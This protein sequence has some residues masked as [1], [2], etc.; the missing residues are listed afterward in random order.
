MYR[1][2]RTPSIWR[3]MNRFQRDMNRLFNQYTPSRTRSA[4]SYPS[5]NI[6]T[7]ESGQV[8]IAEIPGV[9]AEDVDVNVNVD[10]LTISGKRASI[11]LPEG[12]HFVRRE[13]DF[14][15]FTRTIQLPFPVDS[16]HVQANL[17]DGVLS[18]TLPRAE[19]DKPKTITI[20]T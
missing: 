16:E 10:T 17:K 14:G 4:P 13:C 12:A 15:E 19:A 5:I 2:F 18:I 11:D 9:R 8:V 7:N 6:W 20:N 3:E 1:T